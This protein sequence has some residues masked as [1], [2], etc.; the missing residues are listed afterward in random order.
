MIDTSDLKV[1]DVIRC[2]DKQDMIVTDYDLV[3][4]GMAQ[5]IYTRSMVRMSL[6]S[7]SGNYRRS[8]R[9]YERLKI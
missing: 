3:A 4:A 7:R 6:P 2:R 8:R 5:S 1:G 9:S